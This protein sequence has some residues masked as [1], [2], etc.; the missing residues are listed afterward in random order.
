MR[1]IHATAW[2]VM[3]RLHAAGAASVQYDD[4]KSEL[5]VAWCLARDHFD[6]AQGVPFTPYLMRGMYNHINRWIEREINNGRHLSLDFEADGD[7]GVGHMVVSDDSAPIDEALAEKQTLDRFMAKL[8]PRARQFMTLLAEPPAELVE[9]KIAIAARVRY[10]KD[11]GYPRA[12]SNRV[13]C[14]LVFDFMGA[15]ASERMSIMR[16]IKGWTNR[17]QKGVA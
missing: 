14:L 5:M 8:T 9:I 1:L 2:K 11:R 6:P 12:F 10:A 4:V 7:E 15:S 13:S 16:Q 17:F 3:R